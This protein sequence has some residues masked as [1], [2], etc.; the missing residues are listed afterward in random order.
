MSWAH[1]EMNGGNVKDA[2]RRRSLGNILHSLA[3]KP[4]ESFSSAAGSAGRQ[5]MYG[6][7]SVGMKEEDNRDRIEVAD[8]MAGHYEQTLGRIRESSCGGMLY[9]V[10]DTCVFTFGGTREGSG[11]GYGNSV[12]EHCMFGHS[13]LALNS[14]WMPLGV[15]H[16]NIWTRNDADFGKK[17]KRRELDASQ[18][19]SYRWTQAVLDVEAKLDRDQNVLFIQDREADV[20]AFMQTPRRPQTHLL[21]RASQSRRVEVCTGADA[22]EVKRGLL[23]DVMCEA[24]VVSRMTVTV[25]RAANKPERKCDL[26]VQLTP[27][28][29]LPPKDRKGIEP[30]PIDAWVIRARETDPP[31]GEKAIEWTLISTMPVIDG[32]QA[33]SM[34]RIYARR[35]IIERLHYTLKSGGC[36]SERLQMDDAHSI[37]LALALYYITA[38]RLLHMTYIARIQPDAPATV[39]LSEYEVHVL[40]TLAKREIL[41]IND[42]IIEIA[43]LGGFEPYKNGPPPGVKRLWTGLRR[44]EDMTVGWRLA[45]GNLDLNEI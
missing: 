13:V 21:I 41:N 3:E 45:T 2:R 39:A 32:D 10:Q 20:Y 15:A 35:W 33:C 5:A 1:D 27:V 44:L 18:K 22:A 34:V 23:F 12:G 26:L 31:P 7:C 37:S 4:G 8:I 9:L 28:T 25:P 24:P 29:F 14:E 36:N 42:A 6:V 38:W 16:L 43:R 19:E 40:Q 11:I 30:T 17:D